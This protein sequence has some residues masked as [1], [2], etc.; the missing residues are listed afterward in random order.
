MCVVMHVYVLPHVIAM[1][2]IYVIGICVHGVCVVCV[3]GVYGVCVWCVYVMW[4][5]DV[6]CDVRVCVAA[7]NGNG[8]HLRNRYMRA[9]C[10]CMVCVWCVCGVCVWCVYV[11]WVCD[12]R[13]DVRV[14][15]AARNRNGEHLRNR[16]MRAWCVCV[17]CVCMVC[18]CDVGV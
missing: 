14:C 17:W 9:W 8:E 4:V 2:N 12:V 11:I 3:C 7:R 13:C 15:V 10:V 1:G 18:V 16:Y 6:R 5:C